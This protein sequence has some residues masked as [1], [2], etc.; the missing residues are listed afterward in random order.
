MT[1]KTN[2]GS[3]FAAC[4]LPAE[5]KERR[6]WVGCRLVPQRKTKPK[7][8]PVV[9]TD[10]GKNASSTNPATWSTF[11]EARAGLAQGHYQAVGYVLA[12]DVVGIH[13][14]GER[15]VV[16]DGELSEEAQTLVDLC[17]SY[18]EWSISNK[19]V[20]ILLHGTLPWS[21]RRGDKVG[22][23]LTPPSGSS[24]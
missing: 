20:H 16:G 4:S 13:L 23:N 10:P 7:K 12:G 17:S 22:V 15:W 9:A 5:L 18:A 8:I 11:A 3:R 2:G 21:G 24:S 6:Q 19:G 1:Q 14:D